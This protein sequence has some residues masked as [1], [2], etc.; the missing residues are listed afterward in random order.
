MKLSTKTLKVLS[1]FATIN[2][3]IIVKPGNK[4]ETIA[5]AK[6]VLASAEVEETFDVEFGIYDLGEFLNVVALLGDNPELEF[7]DDHVLISNNHSVA[8]YRF[9]DPSILTAPTKSITMPSTDV[10]VNI[11]NE[12]LNQARKAASVLSHSVVS[13]VGDGQSVRLVVKDPKN[14][15][16]NI[17]SIELDKNTK[18]TEKFDLQFL[19]DNLKLL[20]GDYTVDISKK[21]ISKWTLNNDS[22]EYYIAL[23]KTSTYGE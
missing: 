13:L 14:T 1:N 23:E 8:T 2:P 9:A 17:F 22:A 5:E 11:T 19:I 20:S 18:T 10:T 7:S 21:L 12:V 6:N 4:I 15:S 16:S 3:N